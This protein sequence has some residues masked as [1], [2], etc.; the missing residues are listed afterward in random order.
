[1][2]FRRAVY[3]YFTAMGIPVLRGRGFEATDGP[4]APPVAVVNQTLA[5]QMF[6]REDPIGTRVRFGTDDGPW[7]T[8]V[9]VIGDVRHTGLDAPPAP[10]VYIYYLQ[11]PPVNPFLVLRTTGNPLS[12]VPAVRA[13]LRALDKDLY[14]YDIRPMADVRAESVS[15]RRFILLLV[16]AF[17]L[18]ALVMAAVG[19]YGVMA[20]VVSER[21]GEMGIRLAL[22]A[23]PSQV[24]TTVVRQ[25]LSSRSPASRLA[26]RPPCSSRPSWRHSS[27]PWPPPTPKP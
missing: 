21:T 22:G 18:L 17:G 19:V 6:G 9:G 4:D 11:N 8:I 23:R 3:S 10:E 12:L 5:R 27:S 14:A 1:M 24:L 20:L 16:G 2:E 15:Q 25:G 26:S 7:T 13:Q